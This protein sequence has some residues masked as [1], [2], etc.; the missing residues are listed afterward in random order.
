MWVNVRLWLFSYFSF[1]FIAQPKQIESVRFLSE[2]IESGFT[3]NKRYASNVS[4]ISN[5]QGIIRYLYFNE[6]IRKALHAPRIHHQLIPMELMYE[7]DMDADVIQALHNVGHR[8]TKMKA[9][10][11]FAAATAIAREDNK[12]TA[13]YDRRRL[14]SYNVF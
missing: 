11:G 5:S 13:V 9:D 1:H 6:P 8:V 12:L 7:E 14:G 2:H 10:G 3:V 4:L